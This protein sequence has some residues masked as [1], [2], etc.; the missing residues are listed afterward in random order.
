[1]KDLEPEIDAI[2]AVSLEVLHSITVLRSL[3]SGKDARACLLQDYVAKIMADVGQLRQRQEAVAKSMGVP[4][5]PA[6]SNQVR[7]AIL[8]LAGEFAVT[9]HQVQVQLA[10]EFVLGSIAQDVLALEQQWNREPGKF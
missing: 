10:V 9:R 8:F 5:A 3:Y 2:M 1:M 4:P 7:S 6:S